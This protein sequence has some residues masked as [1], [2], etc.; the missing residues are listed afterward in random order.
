MNLL[1]FRCM[2]RLDKNT[3]LCVQCISDDDKKTSDQ[4]TQLDM[5]VFYT[6][7]FSP[8]LVFRSL[9]ADAIHYLYRSVSPLKLKQ[10]ISEFWLRWIGCSR[11]SY[12]RYLFES[13][14]FAFKHDLFLLIDTANG[15]ASSEP[16]SEIAVYYKAFL[17]RQSDEAKFLIRESVIL[18]FLKTGE[19]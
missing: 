12:S 17:D 9:R 15:L 5:A 10:D 16:Q 3:V 1:P 8:D 6:T 13:E 7:N 2:I 19:A 14:Y 11:A 4:K 18:E